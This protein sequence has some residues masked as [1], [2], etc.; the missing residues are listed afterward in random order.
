MTE[1]NITPT[2]KKSLSAAAPG[3]DDS[4]E[5]NVTRNSQDDFAQSHSRLLLMAMVAFRDGDFSVRL[6]TD[7]LGAN[8]RIAE[9]FNQTIAQKQRISSEVTRLS[10]TVGKEGRLKQ[11]MSLPGAIGG[12]AKD[13]ESINTLIDDLVRPTTEIA[14]TIGAVAKGD[15]GQSME[16]EVDGRTLKGEFLRSAKLVNTMIEQLSVFTSEVTRVAREVGTEGKLGGQAQVKGVSG[17]WKDLTDSVNQMAGNLT[18]QVRNIADVTIAV[19]TGDLSKKIT[20]DVRGEILQLKEATNTMVDQLRSFA[21][22]VTRVAREVGTDGRLGGQ[23][24]VP[25]VAGTWK[26]LTDSVNAMATNLTAQVRNIA[27]VT[28]AVARGDLS[29]KIT[30]DVKGEIL[31]LK[32]TINTMVDQLNGFSSEVTRVAREVGTEGKL[33]GQAVVPGVAGTWKDLTDSVNSMASNLTGQVRNIA[34][35]AAAIAKGD[36]SSKIT[37]EVKGEILAL[38]NTMNTMVDQLNGFASEVTRVAR[39]VGTEGKLGGQAAVPGVAGTWK[40]LTDNVN[41]MASNLTGQV[42]NIAEVTTAVANGDLSKKITVDV[43]GE[44]LELK[45]TINTMVDQLNGFAGEVSRVAREVGTEGKLGGQAAVPGVAGTWKDLTDNVN[46]MAS[47]LTGQVRNIA[48]VATAVANGDLSKKITVDV[49]GEILELKNTLN[50]MVDQLNGFASEVSRVAREVGTEGKLG[51]Q[52]VVKGVAGTWKDL[53]DNV[54]SMASNLTGQVRNIA[55]VA[56]AIAK[57]DLSSKITVE[58]KGEILALKN[59]VNTMVDQLNGFAS[60]VTRVAREVGTEG[61]L[62]GQAM[63]PGVAGTWKDL[64]DNVNFMASNLTGQVRNIAEVTTAVA[65]GDLSKKITVEVRGEILELKNTIN[66]MVDQL[67]AFAGE[68]SR[69]ARE[70]GTDGKLGG[71]AAVEGV[72]GTWKDLT[73]NVNSMASNLTGQVRNIAEVTIAV[74]NGDLSKKI[75]VEVEGEIL[76]LKNTINTMVDQLRSFA[77]EVSRVAREVG[78]DGK[79]GGQAQ[80]PG[81][82]GTWKDLTDNVN[83]MASNLTGQVRNIANVATAIARGDLSRKITVDVKGEILQLKETMNTMVEQLSAFASEVTRVA[84]EVGTEGKLGGQAA[85]PGVAGTWKD[86]TDNVNSMA[87]N[88]TGQVRNIAE[89]TIAVANGDLSKKI[90]VDVRG[91]ILQLKETINTMVE[92]LRSFASEVTRVAREVG[93]EGRL[94]VQAVVPGVAGTWKDLT[95]SVNT[96]GANLTAQVRNIAEVTTAVARGDLNRKITV[97]V[98]GEILEL[99]NTINTM[100]DQLNSFA[101]EVT[102]VAR[103]VGTE[104]KLGGQAQVSGVGGTWKDLTDNVNFM[105]SNLTEQVRGIVKVVTAV[106]NGNLTQRLTVQA[107]GEVAALADTI[108]NM[109]D[110]LATFADQVTNV[111]RE[112]GVDGRLGGQANVPGAA[113]TWKDLTGNVNLLAANLTTQVRAIAEVA[114]A[115]TK[116]DLTRSIQVETRGEVAELKDNINTMIS[117]LRETT[118]SNREQDWLKT[119]LAKFSGMLQGQRELDTVGQML[120]TELASLVDANQGTIYHLTDITGKSTLKLLSSYAHG[121]GGPLAEE[122]HLGEGL[123]GQCA[124]E[125]KRILLTNVPP[126][127]ISIYSSLGKARQV[128]IIVLPVLFE[129]QTKAVIEL[130][131]LQNF[132]AGSLAFLELLTQSIGAVFNTIEATMRTEGLL[133]QSQQLT[134][135][136]QSRQSELQQTNEELGTKAKLLAEQNAEVER[137]NAEVEQARRA[138]EEKAAELAL[139]SKYKSEFLANMSHELR[140]PLNSILILSQQLA[141]NSGGNLT[142]KQVEF[143]RNINSSGS[144]LLHLIND[145][146]DLSKIESGT[147]TVEVEEIPFAG[148]RDNID[149]NFRHVAEAKNLP[150]HVQFAEDLPRSMDTDPKRLQQILKNL[151]SNAVKFTSHGHVDVRVG[152]ATNGW[153]ADHPVLNGAQQVLAF[154]VEDTGIGVALEKQRLIFEAFQQ[155]DAGT[156]RKYGGTGLGL[157]ISRELAVLLGGEIKLSSVH[158]MGSTFTL[159]LPLHYSGP[160]NARSAPSGSAQSESARSITVLPVARE[161]HIEDDRNNIGEGDPVF[162][163]VEDDPHYARILLGMARDKGFKGIVA[164][165]GALGLSLARQFHPAAISLDIFLPDMLGWTVLNQLKLDPVTRHIPVQIVTLEEERQHGLAHGAFTYLVKSP[166]TAGMETAFDRIKDFIAP[167]T[168]RLL[169]IEDNDIERQS[170][171]ELLGYKDIELVAVA[172]GGEALAAMLDKSF[173]CVVLDLRLPDM[174]GFEW[175]EKVHADPTLIDVP[176]VVFT[177]KD[178]SAEEQTRLKAMA[179]SIVLKDV[180][181]PERLLD[182]TALFLHRI[183]TELPVEK[184]EMLERL[185]GSNEVLRGRKILVVD[186]DARNIFALTSLLENEEMDVISATNGRAAIDIIQNSADLSIVLMDIM[187]PEMDGYETMR[188]IRKVPKFRTLPILALTAKAMK[189]DREKCLDAGASDYIAKPV[190]TDQLLSLMRVWL[191]R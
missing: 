168:K 72:A 121:G 187:M 3:T 118:E 159:Y 79:L 51:G 4:I 152:F 53:T 78:T 163:I 171:V 75:T 167:R 24:V 90:T 73:D 182:E 16:L 127:F 172:T 123:V 29:R 104:G 133:T 42:R 170:I 179:K 8:A 162:L 39:E 155:A 181:S 141:G 10:E 174:S 165:K 126:D 158:G 131:T 64:T 132:S 6:P 66:T 82:A 27:T 30:V 115:V 99:K 50:T 81:V 153:S 15:L 101:G 58:V 37:V 137:K 150:F 25:G 80:V 52:A 142:G 55:D 14:R 47:N 148:L 100:V 166:T 35:V 38:K 5:S 97:D 67:N 12:W 189:G 7:W 128:S 119:N 107:K 175:L 160:D 60:E 105:A 46:W 112:V 108:N 177:G 91:E 98:K 34:D 122:I 145:I 124:L 178:L 138:L 48:D 114:T 113:G 20:V 86:L 125:K 13:S 140:T 21:S 40:D 57:G 95:D 74:A 65:N 63:V 85:V 62:G 26:D 45:N 139:T 54:N 70:V 116:G 106:A 77:A 61:K 1:T 109:T 147:V 43:R 28:T 151:L 18:A 135:E 87:S 173:D 130:A 23:A 144:D 49:K 83:S 185:H 129:G 102:R 92:Q 96:M 33:G 22:E 84:R 94:G 156:S 143:S 183:V 117:N 190:N 76:A 120:L 146:L 169:I 11:R 71:Q 103:E 2:R 9:A 191:F 36:L 180:Q 31:E 176:V 88:L 44:I 17:V 59:T 111:A 161:E 184:Q 56:T 186:D 149:R 69:V 136:L 164:N 89:V 134:V 188:E 93:T 157:A 32:E 110:T 41:F 154:A 19:A 68:V